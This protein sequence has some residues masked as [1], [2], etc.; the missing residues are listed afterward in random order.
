M[1]LPNLLTISR[2]PFLFMIV[3]LLYFKFQWGPTIAVFLYIIASFTDWFDG[4]IARKWKIVTKLGTFM[5]A[6]IDKIFTLGVFTA[7]LVSDILPRH[8]VFSVLFIITREF[9]ITG[10]RTV[11]ASQNIVI[12]AQGEGKIKTALQMISTV[13]LLCYNSLTVDFQWKYTYDDIAWVFYS[14]YWLFQAA[15]VITILSGVLYLVRFR[16]VFAEETKQK[17]TN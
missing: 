4:Y 2:V 13:F 1:N 16:H 14:G 17:K 10:L 6:L 3:A 11:A 15:T 9:T 12:P 8:T 7:M 5:D